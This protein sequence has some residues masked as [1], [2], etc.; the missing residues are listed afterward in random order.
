MIRNDREYRITKAAAQ[1]FRDALD[2]G[3]PARAL[4]RAQLQT[5][6]IRAQLADLERDLKEYEEL[7]SGEAKRLLTGTLED[8]GDLL[9]KARIARDWTQR[10]LGDRLGLKMQQIQQYEATGYEAASLTRLRDVT[11]ALGLTIQARGALLELPKLATVASRKS[12]DVSVTPRPSG[13]IAAQGGRT[14]S[15]HRTKADA[16]AAGRAESK[17]DRVDVVVQRRDGRIVSTGSYT[18]D[19]LPARGTR[20]KP[21]ARKSALDV[22][23]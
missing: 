15:S 10:E 18:P 4:G 17:R 13:W 20:D 21:Q 16:I 22:K 23:K 12:N 8:L 3:T 5:N 19:S 6:A 2:K 7:Q 9:I 1:R 14:I 11:R